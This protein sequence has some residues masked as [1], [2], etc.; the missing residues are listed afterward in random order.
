KS[1]EG[2]PRIA[3]LS[4]FGFSGTNSHMIIAEAPARNVEE[5]KFER[6][7]QLLTL[8]AKTESAL[9][10]SAQRLESYIE[11]NPSAALADITY[12]LNTGRSHFPYRLALTAASL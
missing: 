6:T 4:S 11:Q 10:D 5:A 1:P 9:K 3:G 7:S 2:K 8:S 12:S